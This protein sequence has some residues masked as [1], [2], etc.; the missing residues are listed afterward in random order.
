LILAEMSGSKTITPEYL[1]LM[2]DRANASAVSF[3]KGLKA[4]TEEFER[5]VIARVLEE[6]DYNKME[7]AIRLDIDVSSL[8]RKIKRYGLGIGKGAGV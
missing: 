1:V 8:Y 6:T 3:G 4:L 5:Q 2:N 7:A